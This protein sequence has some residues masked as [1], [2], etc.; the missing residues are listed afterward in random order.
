MHDLGYYNGKIDLIENMSVPMNDRAAYFGDGVYDVTY[1]KNY[2]LY[3][4]DAHIDRFFRSAEKLRMTVPMS[5]TELADLLCELVSKLDDDEQI[6]YWQITRGTADRNHA[7]P[8]VPANLWV[9][10]RPCPI[11]SMDHAL[12]AITVEDTRFLHCDIKTINLIPNVMAEQRAHDEGCY[13][14][15]FCRNGYVTEAVHANVHILKNG[16]FITHPTDNLILPGIARQ[17]LLRIADKVGV[18]VEIRAFTPEEMMEADEVM[19]SS[20]G[21]FCIPFCEIDRKAVGGRD[22]ATLKKLQNALMADYLEATK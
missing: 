3:C 18:P 14:A 15:I 8:A 17:N 4:L 5:K 21:S 7:F 6:I 9:M 19:L 16:T 10:I 20:S 2:K 1:A 11:K 22:R 13:T 12:T